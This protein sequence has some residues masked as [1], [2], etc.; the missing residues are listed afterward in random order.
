[1]N[2]QDA[3]V[4]VVDDDPLMRKFIGI[5]LKRLPVKV[6]H[7][8]TDGTQGL[9][10]VAEFV[11]DIILSDVHMAPMSGLEFVRQLRKLSDRN[12]AKIPVIMLSADDKEETFHEAVPLGIFG[13]LPK[14]PQLAPLKEKLERALKFR[15]A[16]P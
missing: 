11:P 15:R 5:T 16:Q 13:H 2:F 14:P 12:L 1:M 3:K 9:L 6:I 7:E 8:A 10:A 4:L